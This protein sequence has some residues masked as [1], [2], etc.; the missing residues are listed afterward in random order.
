MFEF[1]ACMHIF[2]PHVFK[3]LSTRKGSCVLSN[4]SYRWMWAACGHWESNTSPLE[5][6]ETQLVDEPSLQCQAL[7]IFLDPFPWCLLGLIMD[8]ID[9]L[10]GS[11]HSE[12]P[13]YQSFEELWVIALTVTHWL[14]LRLI[15]IYG[16]KHKYLE[17]NSTT[18]LFNKT[19]VVS[20]TMGPKISH[21]TNTWQGL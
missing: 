7:T 9:V 4:W 2:A 3:A 6:Q 13:F 19:L 11:E 18:C 10:F 17:S 12:L 16:C 15:T 8:N 5:D 20:S 21:S 14:R 1:F